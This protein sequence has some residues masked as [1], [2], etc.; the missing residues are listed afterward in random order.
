M[1]SVENK[2]EDDFYEVSIQTNISQNMRTI[3]RGMSKWIASSVGHKVILTVSQTEN[4]ND[5]HFGEIANYYNS[6]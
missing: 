4:Q 3:R 6:S 5:E 2:S 1:L